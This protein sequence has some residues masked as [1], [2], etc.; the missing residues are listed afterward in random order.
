MLYNLIIKRKRETKMKLTKEQKQ[1]IK[2]QI[3]K[4][5]APKVLNFEKEITLKKNENL[6]I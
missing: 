5:K 6:T 4:E 1:E 3:K 2:N